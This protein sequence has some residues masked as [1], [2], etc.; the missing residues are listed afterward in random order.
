MTKIFKI[1][2][3]YLKMQFSSLSRNIDCYGNPGPRFHNGN[4]TPGWKSCLLETEGSLLL[5]CCLAAKSHLTLCGPMDCSPPGSSVCEISQARVL[6]WIAISSSRGSS[7]SRIKPTSPAQAGR[8]LPAEQPGRPPHRSLVPRSAPLLPPATHRSPL[9]T[10]RSHLSTCLWAGDSAQ[11]G[12]TVD[13][14]LPSMEELMQKL[15]APILWPPDFF[16][17]NYYF[18]LL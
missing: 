5:T 9:T 1:K 3:F 11:E 6:E 8:F 15:E 7:Q 17:F 16:F 10:H 2:R 13:G 12:A 14:V 18:F 4:S